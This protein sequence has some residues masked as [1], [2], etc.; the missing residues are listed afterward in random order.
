MASRPRHHLRALG[1]VLAA[2]GALLFALAMFTGADPR[3]L[4]AVAATALVLTGVYL[5]L[6][7]AVTAHA[8][9]RVQPRFQAASGLAGLVV[10][11]GLDYAITGGVDWTLVIG[12]GIGVMIGSGFFRSRTARR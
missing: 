9:Y 1:L 4:V 10:A 3:L 12:V 2:L 5:T 6:P 8:R 7:S 11:A